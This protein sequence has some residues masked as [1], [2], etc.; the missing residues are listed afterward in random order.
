MDASE[1]ND[2]GGSKRRFLGEVTTKRAVRKGDDVQALKPFQ[3][4]LASLRNPGKTAP[5]VVGL[6]SAPG[7]KSGAVGWNACCAVAA[8][9]GRLPRRERSPPPPPRFIAANC[10]SIGGGIE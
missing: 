6:A 10:S 7:K 9:G 3:L 1:G 5:A 4:Q 2:V 8:G